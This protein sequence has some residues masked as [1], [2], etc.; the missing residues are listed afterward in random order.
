MSLV[1]WVLVTRIL[2]YYP[3]DT[4]WSVHARPSK[5]FYFFHLL[6]EFSILNIVCLGNFFFR[7]GATKNVLDLRDPGQPTPSF[8]TTPISSKDLFIFFNNNTV[9]F[10][11]LSR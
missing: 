6:V 7:V 9:E 8:L 10:I 2:L 5:L 1:T 4:H 3:V 11:P